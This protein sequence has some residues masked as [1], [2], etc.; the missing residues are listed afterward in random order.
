MLKVSRYILAA[1]S[2]TAIIVEYQAYLLTAD[3]GRQAK[4]LH[5]T[6]AEVRGLAAILRTTQKGVLVT[7]NH[8]HQTLSVSDHRCEVRLA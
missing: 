8:P 1:A 5:G 7:V 2:A 6:A 4:V 3:G